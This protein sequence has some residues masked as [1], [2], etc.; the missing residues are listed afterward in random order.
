[1]TRGDALQPRLCEHATEAIDALVQGNWRLEAVPLEYRDCAEKLLAML[2]Q[3]CSS[4]ELAESDV[5]ERTLR[6]LLSHASVEPELAEVD[7]DALD[8]WTLKGFRSSSVPGS[9]RER[10]HRHE[11]LAGL[12][13]RSIK[14]S[15]IVES[16]D[17]VERTIAEVE[18]YEHW[19][20]PRDWR[21]SLRF[22]MIDAA[23]VAALLLLVV[24]V[25]MPVISSIRY[26]A[27]R[28]ANSA[29]FA[30]ASV[31]FGAYA[32]DH[33]E[34]LPVYTPSDELVSMIPAEQRRWWLVGR[35]PLQS[36]SAN[37]YTLARLGYTT[38]ESLASPGNK[39]AI[40]RPPS[41]DAVDW[42]HFEE[43]SYS[44]RVDTGAGE[45]EKWARRGLVILT[46]RSPVTIKAHNNQPIDPYENS[47]NHE[48]RGQHVLYGD[49][50][51]DWLS[52]PWLDRNDHIYLPRFIE[53]LINSGVRRSGMM[54]I[55]GLERPDSIVDTFVGP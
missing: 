55:R 39:H 13:S 16:D 49:G 18:K 47:P 46:D 4:D 28:R 26:E 10:A 8:A 48:G 23:A 1:M 27:R 14:A 9:L 38:L 32:S 54:P 20:E 7:A 30:V 53:R 22:R 41:R 35:D 6:T 50:S 25:A 29:N 31:G 45:P 33:D 17:L 2:G 52:S 3:A 15:P 40:T 5:A 51:V 37:L 36:N 11:L 12:I 44:Y 24:S 19:V 34:Q 43:V 21:M 42:G